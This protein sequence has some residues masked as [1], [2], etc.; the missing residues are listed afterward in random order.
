MA[1]SIDPSIKKISI[2]GGAVLADFEGE[3][4]GG[5]KPR[6]TRKQYRVSA[7]KAPSEDASL[8]GAG[9]SPGTLIQLASSH[10]PGTVI[11]AVAASPS[12]LTEAGAPI[13][14]IAPSVSGGS[15]PTII[16]SKP[17]I[18]L[19]KTK[20]KNK[21]LFT[22]PKLL[23][24]PGAAAKKKTLKKVNMSMRGLTRKLKKAHIIRKTASD[25]GIDVIKKE[26]IKMGLV[27]ADT[28]APDDV[29]RQIYSDVETMKKRAL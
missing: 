2:T 17:T 13:G 14:R 19:S 11:S 25:K 22:A 3:Q 21:V 8:K 5:R 9:T 7:I 4:E 28:S 1:D 20:K 23:T 10:V 12:E 26:L 29:L 24:A 27:K 16:L 6:K 18:I 15:K